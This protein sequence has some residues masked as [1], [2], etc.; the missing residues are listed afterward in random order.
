MIRAIRRLPHHSPGMVQKGGLAGHSEIDAR[1]CDLRL[2]TQRGPRCV[3]RE[4]CNAINT[5][6]LALSTQCWDSDQ[7]A[8]FGVAVSVHP[9]PLGSGM[10]RPS[11]AHVR[12]HD[13]A[14]CCRVSLA[15]C[16]PRR[17]SRKVAEMAV[18]GLFF[19]HL[20]TSVNNL[21]TATSIPARGLLVVCNLHRSRSSCSPPRAV[22]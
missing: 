4:A 1:T 9:Y 2:S 11:T 18:L 14:T 15:A 16:K 10:S 22:R 19:E 21:G 3:E 12:S 7:S 8:E 20:Y 6:P 17:R 5:R 13:A